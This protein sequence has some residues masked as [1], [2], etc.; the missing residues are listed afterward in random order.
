MTLTTPNH[1]IFY[2]LRRL[3]YLHNVPVSCARPSL[4]E[5]ITQ[6]FV[7]FYAGRFRSVLSTTACYRSNSIAPSAR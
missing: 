3:S 2:T 5:L 4:E 6:F 7:T 1:P